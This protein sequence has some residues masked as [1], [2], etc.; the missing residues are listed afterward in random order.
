[1]NLGEVTR[2]R[3]EVSNQREGVLRLKVGGLSSI[4]W[5]SSS[6]GHE[7]CDK[8]D[9]RETD[10][11]KRQNDRK[12]ILNSY[13]PPLLSS[14]AVSVLPLPL[15]FPVSVPVPLPVTVALSAPFSIIV[16]MPVTTAGLVAPAFL[17]GP[18][19][20]TFPRPLTPGKE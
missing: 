9:R 6:L 19:V 3:K 13:T 5:L 17:P 16:L 8:E 11:R 14:L 18:A 20:V 15:S 4:A 10:K 2:R 1:M 12:K 7:S